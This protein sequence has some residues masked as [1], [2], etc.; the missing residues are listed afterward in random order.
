MGKKSVFVVAELPNAG[1]ANCLFVWARAAIY[2]HEHKLP[3]LT[4]G[5]NRIHLGPLLRGERV[6]RYYRGYFKDQ[7]S[8]TKE[9]ILRKKI[10][11]SSV[12]FNPDITTPAGNFSYIVFNELPHWSDYFTHLKKHRG[13]V[14][15]LL[16]ANLT[17]S[18]ASEL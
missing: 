4:I 15:E 17:P 9:F 10:Q 16:L 18:L 2:A 5:W 8:V 1:L 3:M 14:K 11:K 6:K 7:M 12:Q 13:L